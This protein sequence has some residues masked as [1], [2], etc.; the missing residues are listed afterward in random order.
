M[1]PKER[2]EREKEHRREEIIKAG[3]K[4]FLKKGLYG[5][6]MD[7]IARKCELSKGTLYLYFSSKEQLYF[8]IVCRAMDRLYHTFVQTI[9]GALTPLKSSHALVKVIIVFLKKK[10]NILES[11]HGSWILIMISTAIFMKSVFLF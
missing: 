10:G 1:G 9:E 8:E 7:E 5:T 3:E 11:L 4:L 6:T 2:K